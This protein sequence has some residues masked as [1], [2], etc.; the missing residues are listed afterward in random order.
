MIPTTASCYSCHKD[1]GAVDTSFVQF[2]PT[3]MPVAKSKGTLAAGYLKE[4]AAPAQK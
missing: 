2:Y 1:H 3:L 4:I